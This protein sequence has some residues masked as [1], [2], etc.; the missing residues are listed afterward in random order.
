MDT[1]QTHGKCYPL[2]IFTDLFPKKSAP[3]LNGKLILTFHIMLQYYSMCE[4]QYFL[5]H[6]S[7]SLFTVIVGSEIFPN[8]KR[9]PKTTNGLRLPHMI[10]TW[11]NF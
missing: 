1:E 10:M 9:F 2:W 5:F 4:Q 7:P 8:L 3:D 6:P 11:C